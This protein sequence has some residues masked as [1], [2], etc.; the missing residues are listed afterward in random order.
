MLSRMNKTIGETTIEIVQGDITALEVDA[1]VNAANRHLAHGGGIA[2]A[3]VRK[4]GMSIQA[5]S[6]ALIAKRGPL[7]TGAAAI[8]SGGKLPAKFVI[9]TVGPIWG[10]QTEDESDSLLRKAVRSCL[11]LA[12]EKALK[13]IAFPAISTGIY[14][15]P[16]DRAAPLMLKEAAEYLRDTAKLERVVFC[17]YDER[18]YRIFERAFQGL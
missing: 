2:L 15:F 13:S 5:E 1:I 8:T 12:D 17:L 16:I 14:G 3:I 7:K 4:G 18:S 6:T 9:H 10:D 11:A